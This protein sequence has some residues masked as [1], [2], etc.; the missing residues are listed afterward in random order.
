M[1]QSDI[2]IITGQ[3]LV[4]NT[5]DDLLAVINPKSEVIVTGPSS[6]ILPDLLFENKVSVIGTIRITKPEILFSLV[7]EGGTGYHLFEYCAQKI[8]ILK[9]DEK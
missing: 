1:P 2:V 4:N 8:C 3:T 6:G 5:I 7:R 9:G